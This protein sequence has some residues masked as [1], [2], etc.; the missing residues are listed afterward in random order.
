MDIVNRVKEL[1]E[2]VINENNYSLCDVEYEKENGNYYLRV[3][4]DG[5]KGI[6]VDDCVAVSKLINPIIDEID[7]ITDSYMLDV[8]SKGV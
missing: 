4:I 1:I 8:C 2:D 6:N 3:I 7:F 5:K